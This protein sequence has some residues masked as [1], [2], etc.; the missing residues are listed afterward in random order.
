MKKGADL[1]LEVNSSD[2]PPSV[3]LPCGTSFSPDLKCS[4]KSET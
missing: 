1:H 4:F 3:R 2:P